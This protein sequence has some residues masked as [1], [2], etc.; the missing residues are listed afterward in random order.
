MDLPRALLPLPYPVPRAVCG[1]SPLPWGGFGVSCPLCKPRAPS[2]GSST[3][4]SRAGP[5]PAPVAAPQTHPSPSW[6]SLAPA[7]SHPAGP[8]PPVDPWPRGPLRASGR[9]VRL[10][11]RFRRPCMLGLSAATSGMLWRWYKEFK[12]NIPHRSLLGILC[13]W[14]LT[15]VV[16]VGSS[17]SSS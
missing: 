17:H 9:C 5:G 1:S 7:V 14:V 15:F 3:A 6:G 13:W 8:N 4:C 16:L 12:W 2:P 10:R 11:A